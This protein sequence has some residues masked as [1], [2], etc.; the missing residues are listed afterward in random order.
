MEFLC[1][2]KIENNIEIII[3]IHPYQHL[4][5]DKLSQY[6]INSKYIIKS[7]SIIF[8]MDLETD[9]IINKIYTCDIDNIIQYIYD[10]KN[11]NENKS[12]SNY[13]DIMLEIN[14]DDFFKFIYANKFSF[15]NHIII[16]KDISYDKIELSIFKNIRKIKFN[17]DPT[18]FIKK[19]PPG[20]EEFIFGNKYNKIINY[21]PTG[22]QKLTLPNNF[23]SQLNISNS[24]LKILIFNNMFNNKVNNL[25][26]TLKLIKFGLEFNHQVDNLPW[27]IQEII[28]GKKFN[29]QVDNLPCSIISLTFGDFFNQSVS[30]LPYG[31]KN[32]TFKN[33]ICPQLSCKFNKCLNN[34]PDSVEILELYN[35]KYSR[36]INKLPKSLKKFKTLSNYAY[37]YFYDEKTNQKKFDTFN[38][39]NIE[40]I[41]EKQNLQCNIEIII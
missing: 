28:F 21:I 25:P 22:L 3:S 34:L 7:S 24:N 38:K 2:I 16:G 18:N 29:C 12:Y 15:I 37:S 10:F 14:N 40:N 35:K 13:T 39:K 1:K 27:G 6:N 23:N 9:K 32:I 17:K 31:L 20:I 41:I 5:K 19:I 36:T 26:S 8:Y 4:W 30:N 33:I 11:D